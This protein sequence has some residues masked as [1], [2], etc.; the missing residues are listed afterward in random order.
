[1]ISNI[2][3]TLTNINLNL[4]TKEILRLQEENEKLKS[5]LK[6]TETQVTKKYFNKIVGRVTCRLNADCV[7]S[8][9]DYRQQ[10]HWMRSQS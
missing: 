10:M 5:R 6:A 8:K 3:N 1:M 4:L 9:L 7:L 2:K